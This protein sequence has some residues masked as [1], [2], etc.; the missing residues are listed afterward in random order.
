[1]DIGQTNNLKPNMAG[2]DNEVLSP[3]VQTRAKL[4]SIAV[5][6]LLFL[7]LDSSILVINFWLSARLAEDSVAINLAGRQRMLSQKITKDLILLDQTKNVAGSPYA[8]D[9]KQSVV[10]FDRVMDAFEHGGMVQGGNGEETYLQ[11]ASTENS[12]ILLDQVSAIWGKAYLPFKSYIE[13]EKEIPLSAISTASR[14][15]LAKGDSLLALLNDYTFLLERQSVAYT[16]KLRWVQVVIFFLAIVNFLY[17]V[18][19]FL[20]HGEEL[21]ELDVKLEKALSENLKINARLRGRVTERTSYVKLLE[22]SMKGTL[23]AISNMIEQ[24][25]PYTAGHERRVGKIA[26]DIAAEMG[27]S[28]EK[29]KELELICLVHDIGKI[30]IP[31]EILTKPGRLT[32]LEYEV[33]KTHVVKGYEILKDIRFPLPIAEI[34]YQHHERMDGS[35]YPRG[36]KGNEILPEAC[37]LAVADVIESM[38]SHRPYRPALGIE[39][40]LEEVVDHKGTRYASDVVDALLRLFKNQSYRLPE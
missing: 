18:K 39:L 29:C 11:A 2:L 36:L 13:H 37:I 15:M 9:L 16:H 10:L 34:I 8:S 28:N 5:L 38:A 3:V 25:D 1:M 12:A 26:A 6:I 19:L 30:G 22:E 32:P 21:Q 33:V 24:R 35:G 17:I 31:T 40:A 23:Q 14:E 20:Q 27:W 4:K 7:V